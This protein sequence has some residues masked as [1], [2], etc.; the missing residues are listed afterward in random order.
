MYTTFIIIKNTPTKNYQL[1]Y[2]QELSLIC[3]MKCTRNKNY[4]HFSPWYLYYF[5]IN[6]RKWNI[7][8]LRD[9]C[10]IQ[11]HAAFHSP[12]DI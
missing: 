10:P 4:K 11:T 5:L 12:L 1:I 3:T 7:V 6:W 9:I 8:G 2:G